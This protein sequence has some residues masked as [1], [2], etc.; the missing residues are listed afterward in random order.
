[1]RKIVKV[2][3]GGSRV[4]D[5]KSSVIAVRPAT[6]PNPSHQFQ[7]VRNLL[8]AVDESEASMNAVTYIAEVIAGLPEI[9]RIHIC[10]A[11]MLPSYPPELFEIVER[12]PHQRI[13]KKAAVDA[14]KSSCLKRATDKLQGA[15]IPPESIETDFFMAETNGEGSAEAIS[16][17][18]QQYQCDVVV[19]GKAE[20]SHFHNPFGYQLIKR[21]AQAMSTKGVNIWVV[22]SDVPETRLD[23]LRCMAENSITRPTLSFARTA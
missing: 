17:L 15:G 1:V 13:W 16:E 14:A 21:L 20:H 3:G 4:S 22:F 19:V 8:I 11:Q 2:A 10:L 12:E 23:H 7:T 6:H 9:H 18:V 5:M